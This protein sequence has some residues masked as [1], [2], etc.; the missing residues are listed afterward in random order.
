M[1]TTVVVVLI[2]VPAAYVLYRGYDVRL[3]LF[4]AALLLACLAGKPW[5]PFDSFRAMMANG[6]VIAPIC[7]ALGYAY[8]LKQIGA[9]QELVRLLTSPMR[10]APWLLIPGGC[11]VGFIINIAIVSQTACVAALSLILIPLMRAVRYSPQTIAATLVL[12]CSAGGDLLN[13]GDSEMVAVV[14]STAKNGGTM[15]VA[16]NRLVVPHV[17]GFLAA[18]AAFWL[19]TRRSTATQSPQPAAS[20]SNDPPPP[21]PADSHPEAPLSPPRRANLLKAGLPLLPVA[22]LFA[23]WPQFGLFPALLEMY[24]N[25]LPVTHA[26]IISTIIAMFISRTDPSAETKSFFEGMGYGYARVVSLL[27]VATCLID[28]MKALGMVDHLVRMVGNSGPAG[29]MTAGFFTWILA[30]VSG[31]ATAPSIGFSLAVLP[32]LSATDLPGALDLGSLG[33]IMASYGRTM[34]PVAAVVVFTSLQLGVTPLQI[35][36]RTAPALAVGAVVVFAVMLLR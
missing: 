11:V 33:A 27:I 25:G 23:T 4:A 34:S 35:V 10:R 29:M 5:I 1:I 16:W 7:A 6:D 12:G 3:V 36:R 30:V 31:S 15:P 20:S 13:P 24:P 28:S 32:G 21:H 2:F 17:L 26:I 19:L 14:S 9:D 22:M 18:T 8:V